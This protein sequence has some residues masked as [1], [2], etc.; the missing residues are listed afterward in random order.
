MN[1]VANNAFMALTALGYGRRLVSVVPPDAPLSVRSSLYARAKAG[2]DPRGKVP[3]R[4]WPDGSWSGYD[5]LA[6]EATPA[7]AAEWAQSGAGAGM[8]TG[9][10]D[11]DEWGVYAID[12]DCFDADQA[13]LVKEMVERC[14]GTLP[15][16]VGR[17]PKALY[18][19]RSR[20]DIAYRRVSFAGADGR[21]D[22]VEVLG[23]GR[24][25]V[26]WG[27][28]PATMR[29]YR[30]TRP[31]PPI[32][33][34]P[35]ISAEKLA[36][37]LDQLREAL[38][39]ARIEGGQSTADVDQDSLKGPLEAVRAAVRATPN[40]T[41][42]FPEREH[43]LSM[44]YAIKAALADHPAEAF[45]TWSEWCARWDG[46]E[47]DPAVI[48]ADWRRM[49]PPY[50]RGWP[51]LQTLAES[52]S[53]GAWSRAMAWFEPPE[54]EDGASELFGGDQGLAAQRAGAANAAPLDGW[55]DVFSLLETPAPAQEW[56]VDGWIPKDVVTLLTGD[57]EAGKSIIGLQLCL[58][59]A[60]GT[61]WL[62][63]PVEHGRAMFVSAE[64]DIGEAHRRLE[65]LMPGG[66]SGANGPDG[67]GGPDRRGGFLLWP[68]AGGTD[69]ALAAGGKNGAL[70]FTPR[71]AACERAIRAFR[72]AVV[73]L[74]TLGILFGGQENDRAQVQAF[75]S[76]VQKWALEA[77]AAIVVIGH[78]SKSGMESGLGYSGSTAWNNAVRS[79]LYL[80]KV[81]DGNVAE[82]KSTRRVLTLMKANRGVSGSDIALRMIGGRMLRE[83]DGDASEV[84][85]LRQAEA[86]DAVMQMTAELTK[87]GVR[88]SASAHAGNYAPKVMGAHALGA[89]FTREELQSAMVALLADGRLKVETS[90][91][92]SRRVDQLA[93]GNPAGLFDEL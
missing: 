49:K 71:F 16:R 33:E 67:P 60:L 37:F 4:R 64:D 48:E 25:F 52:A 12:A 32:G 44:G 87:A 23:A 10:I 6:R 85:A 83:G 72:P 53:G 78:P 61:E 9:K 42:Q 69:L 3:G 17:D 45:E 90:G 21:T 31:L 1:A 50:R 79:R 43:Y 91:P 14:F 2:A 82:S 7:D 36:A 93:I 40:S 15:C 65:R 77:H 28:H 5:F 63:M 39:Q 51:W 62:G 76:G 18:V 30:W 11:G 74:D 56:L 26:A 75:V 92:P 81:K 59:T 22:R 86:R 29:P 88:L 47:N 20:D 35:E 13:R 19:F 24:Q 8:R 89:A 34:L 66:V 27:V 73:V 58:A 80:K 41:A 84:K 38:P 70:A 54:A 55:V 68:I 46:G 57:G